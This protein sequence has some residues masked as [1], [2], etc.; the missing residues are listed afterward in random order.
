MLERNSLV[1]TEVLVGFGLGVLVP[2]L[3][4]QL[5]RLEMSAGFRSRRR[6]VAIGSEA[7]SKTQATQ[8]SDRGGAL[9]DRR[10]AP[11]RR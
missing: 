6:P 5:S 11:Q 4:C 3:D 7:E 8:E 9:G 2:G 1:M 10:N